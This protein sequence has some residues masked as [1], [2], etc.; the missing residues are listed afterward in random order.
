[1]ILFFFFG[2]VLMNSVFSL[3]CLKDS[4]RVA[5]FTPGAEEMR[6]LCAQLS[7][8]CLRQWHGRCTRLCGSDARVA[9]GYAVRRLARC[10][11]LPGSVFAVWCLPRQAEEIPPGFLGLAQACLSLCSAAFTMLC[12]STLKNSRK[13]ARVS[14]RPKPSVPRVR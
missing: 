6:R 10:W 9:R 2:F 4:L 7:A 14:L 8:C 11:K 3:N 13:A 12:A 5:R 1:M